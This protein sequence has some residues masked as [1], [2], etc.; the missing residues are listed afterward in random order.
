[1]KKQPCP[2]LEK[3]KQKWQNYELAKR[4]SSKDDKVR[5]ATSLT[6]ISDEAVDVCN[7][8]ESNTEGDGKKVDKV[9]RKFFHSG[10]TLFMK[11]A[12]SFP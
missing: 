11:D 6:V 3:F 10:R 7:T 12:C 4:V 8:T 9:F 1:M 5:V 2:E